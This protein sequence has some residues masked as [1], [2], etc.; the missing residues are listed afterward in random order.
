MLKG[1]FF[2]YIQ[3]SNVCNYYGMWI[4][5][6]CVTTKISRPGYYDLCHYYDLCKH[7]YYDLCHYYDLCFSFHTYQWYVSYV[8]SAVCAWKFILMKC[9]QT[10]HKSNHTI[11]ISVTH[12]IICATHF[13]YMLFFHLF[14]IITVA[15]EGIIINRGTTSFI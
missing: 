10:F 9:V 2:L 6:V 15:G 5:M 8:L 4:I 12:F 1:K 14:G 3:K 7:S 11:M 13:T